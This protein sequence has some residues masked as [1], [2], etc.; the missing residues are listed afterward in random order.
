MGREAA[1]CVEQCWSHLAGKR[2]LQ[3]TNEKVEICPIE[4]NESSLTQMD[5][6]EAGGH[7]GCS[8]HRSSEMVPSGRPVRKGGTNP[9]PF[10]RGQRLNWLYLSMY[11]QLKG[12]QDSRVWNSLFLNTDQCVSKVR[13]C[14]WIAI[15]K[16]SGNTAEAPRP[17]PP[18]SDPRMS[19]RSHL[20]ESSEEARSGPDSS[21]Y[22]KSDLEQGVIFFSCVIGIWGNLVLNQG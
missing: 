8:M 21:F 20:D 22:W 19:F 11:G 12:L 4:C 17:E 2:P 7:P 16:H 15:Q 5:T 13:R 14:H 3:G 10:L 6:G 9:S 18:P 1:R